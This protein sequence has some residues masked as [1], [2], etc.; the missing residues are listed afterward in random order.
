M[1]TDILLQP[2]EGEFDT[3]AI[4]SY[5]DKLHYA[6]RDPVKGRTYMVAQDSEWLE[7]ALKKRKGN[8]T[9]FPYAVGLVDV[10]PT[11]VSVSFRTPHVEPLR[12][13]VEWLRQHYQLRIMDE[14]FHDLTDRCDR[15][16]DH[17]F[18]PRSPA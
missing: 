4:E 16:L 8:P 9:S 15:D 2:I 17:L 14:G 1:I 3:K 18:G 5:L 12:Q 7:A 10:W 6:A 11:R 13:F